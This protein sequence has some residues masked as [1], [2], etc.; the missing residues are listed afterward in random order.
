MSVEPAESAVGCPHD[1]LYQL[2]TLPRAHHI[3]GTPGPST[4]PTVMDRLL[5]L[6][7]A[8]PGLMVV[9]GLVLVGTFVFTLIGVMTARGGQSLRPLAFVAIFFALVVVPQAVW[10]SLVAAGM[11]TKAPT[12]TWGERGADGDG[13][14]ARGE[15]GAGMVAR[16]TE[17]PLVVEGGRFRDPARLFGSD[18]DT[19]LIRRDAQGIFG[20]ALDRATHAELAFIGGS[21]ETALAA[22]FSSPD[23]ARAARDGWLRFFGLAEPRGEAS[24]V[25]VRRPV[26]DVAALAVAGTVLHV[27]TAADEG[28]VLRRAGRSEAVRLTSADD[29]AAM[30]ASR[31]AAAVAAATPAAAPFRVPTSWF[32]GWMLVNLAVAALWFFKGVPWAAAVKGD[33]GVAPAGADALRERLHAAAGPDLPFAVTPGSS[34]NELEATWRYADAQWLDLARARKL[35][36]T[37]RIVMRLD[38][39]AKVVRVLEYSAAFDASA[40]RGGADVSWQLSRGITFFQ[41]DYQKVFGLQLDGRGRPT[42][43]LGYEWKFNLQ[44]MKAPLIAAVTRAGW[45]WRPVILDAPPYL[46]WAT[47]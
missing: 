45:E 26:G 29:P 24:V 37:Q 21:G 36:R 27:W 22:A 28:A 33:T 41:V 18:V 31:P 19:S 20:P 1:G 4:H 7:R 39:A 3:S 9:G 8:N 12:N 5:T 40:G 23:E 38:D 30:A 14:E 17:V 13:T 11:V 35:R 15:D 47:E 2:P 32:V 25:I 42:G 10:H 16:A 43:A 6:L 44:E 46:R 34:P